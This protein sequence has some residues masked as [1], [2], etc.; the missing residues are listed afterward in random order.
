MSTE[1]L[2]GL[3]ETFLGESFFRV[4]I[5]DERTHVRGGR[6]LRTSA[7]A[8]EY[9]KRFQN[10]TDATIDEL[11]LDHDLG[12]DDSIRPV[13]DELERACFEG[14]PYRIRRIFVHTANPVGADMIMRSRLL[15]EN[16][17]LARI[18]LD[19]FKV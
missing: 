19:S 18:G 11:Y 8:L 13:V 2:F 10:Q 6:H 4:V 12:G 3:T 15:N 1:H 5:D 9:L 17:K 16:Y 7:D 14:E